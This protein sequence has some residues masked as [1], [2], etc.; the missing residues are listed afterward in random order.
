MDLSVI[1]ALPWDNWVIWGKS[2]A[3]LGLTFLCQ[4]V[5]GLDAG[6]GPGTLGPEGAAPT[7]QGPGAPNLRSARI[8]VLHLPPVGPHAF[9]LPLSAPQFPWGEWGWLGGNVIMCG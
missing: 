8:D 3:F 4:K 1:P 7:P 5:L 2:K 9:R 6:Q